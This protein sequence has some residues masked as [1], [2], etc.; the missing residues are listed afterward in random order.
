MSWSKLWSHFKPTDPS[1]ELDP[2]EA[3]TQGMAAWNSGDLDEAQRLLE[4]A[5]AG[6]PDEL[7]HV[8][9]LGNLHHQRGNL[10][11]ALS[12]HRKAAELAPEHPGAHRNQGRVFIELGR[13]H[14]AS[15]AL[16]KS[17]EI[18]PTHAESAVLCAQ[19]LASSDDLVRAWVRCEQSI[20]EGAASPELHNLYLELLMECN[21]VEKADRASRLPD[22]SS[23]MLHRMGL[24]YLGINE[25]AQ[26]AEVLSRARVIAPEDHTLVFHLAIAQ[27][28]AGDKQKALDSFARAAQL[29]PADPISRANLGWLQLQNGQTSEALQSMAEATALEARLQAPEEELTRVPAHRI[30]HDAE[31]FRHILEH[32]ELSEEARPYAHAIMDL[33]DSLGESNAPVDL[34]HPERAP[35]RAGWSL[36]YH[37]PEC[38]ALSNGTL[39]PDLD[40]QKIQSDYHA[41]S[42]E[43]VIVDDLLNPEALAALQKWCREA[44]IWKRSYDNGYVGAFMRSGLATPLIVQLSEE[45]RQSLPQ[46]LKEHRLEQCWAFKCDNSLK[47][48]NRHADVAAV[49]VNFW[50]APDDANQDH[51]SGGLVVWDVESP[52][53]WPFDDYNSNQEKMQAFLDQHNAQPITVTH[54]CNRALVFNSTVF[55]ESDQI[56]FRPD[57]VNRRINITLLYGIRLLEN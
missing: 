23:E 33:A 30:R 52:P 9:N 16:E 50:I 20:E 44:T 6:A 24:G 43:M 49:N 40:F 38:P 14:E 4:Q 55:H 29:A 3:Y 39:N 13:F 19:A 22:V 17:L 37:L 27:K 21:E 56:Q 2:A 53:D 7:K 46:V 47:A 26:A 45:L 36:N 54:R 25:P 41:S 28:N 51:E 11:D 18:E 57:Y 31:Q 48:V 35:I 42:P 34:T 10:I 1:L 12:C 5:T 8:G 32:S 15:R